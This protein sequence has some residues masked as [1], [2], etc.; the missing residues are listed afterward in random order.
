MRTALALTLALLG[1]PASALALEPFSAQY[2]ADFQSVPVSGSAERRLTRNEDGS[3]KL[4]FRASMLIAALREDSQFRYEAAQFMPYSYELERTGL[5][6]GKYIR[7]QFD[8]DRHLVTGTDRGDPVKLEL[9]SGLLD[10]STYQLA[11]QEDVAAGK[12][13][14][15]YQ[16]VDGDEVETYDFRVLGKEMVDITG[17]QVE[18][19]KV[20]RVRDPNKSR[21]QTTLWFA[22]NWGYLLVRLHQTEKDGKEYRIMLEQGLIGDRE[23]KGRKN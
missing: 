10:K 9:K 12:T 18:A 3:W 21:R 19:I 2:T 17:G 11:L 13:A 23:V 20:E 1:L 8:W 7:H 14:M 15:T 4:H 6:K 5:G 22:P 16:V